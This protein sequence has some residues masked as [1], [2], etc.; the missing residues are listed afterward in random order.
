MKQI[1]FLNHHICH[2]EN[3]TE[4]LANCP[5]IKYAYDNGYN[6][7]INGGAIQ[8]DPQRAKIPVVDFVHSVMAACHAC[9]NARKR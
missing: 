7:R 2:V 3:C 8:I 6:Y 1:Y 4:S 5:V 9:S